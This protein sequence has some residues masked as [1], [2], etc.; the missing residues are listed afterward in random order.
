MSTQI[1]THE[2]HN[3]VSLEALLQ[4]IEAQCRERIESIRRQAA[5]QRDAIR[6]SARDQAAELLRETRRRERRLA[7]ER[8]RAERARQ[9]ARI[10]QRQLA[11]QQQRARRGVEAL[12][13]ALSELWDQPTARAAW[14]ARVVGDARAVLPDD[15]WRVR[16]PGDWS[17]DDDAE[18]TVDEAASGV[19]IDWCADSALRHGFIIET[20]RARVDATIDGLTARGDRIAGVLLAELP[21]PDLE[22]DA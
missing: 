18:R 6:R 2:A 3:R 22:V 9:E 5:E 8:V 15:H 10:R 4:H 21:E 1:E 17:P 19:R 12:C 16:H 20:T 7:H 13:Q 14:L 11:L